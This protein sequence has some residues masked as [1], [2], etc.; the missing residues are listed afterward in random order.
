MVVLR[1][2]FRHRRRAE[3]CPPYQPWLTPY[4]RFGAGR[5]TKLFK[6]GG[7]ALR[8]PDGAA[9]RPYPEK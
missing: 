9:R 1:S 5:R 6:G 7:I 8:G 3:D 2:F 4:R